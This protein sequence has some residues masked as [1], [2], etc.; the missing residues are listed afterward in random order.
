[1]K[2][3]I[4]WDIA[5]YSIKVDRRFR[6]ACCLH[7]H[8]DDGDYTAPNVVVE[9]LSLLLRIREVPISNFGPETGYPD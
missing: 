9:W 1:M 8:S 5:P 2:M 4:F 6:G 7:Y 3:T